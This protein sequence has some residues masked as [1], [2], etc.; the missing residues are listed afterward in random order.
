MFRNKRGAIGLVC[1]RLSEG[2]QALQRAG[3]YVSRQL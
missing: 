1:S 3:E 2:M